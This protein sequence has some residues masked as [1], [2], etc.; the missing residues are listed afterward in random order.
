MKYYAYILQSLKDQKFYIG[1]TSKNPE[2]RLKEHN[3]KCVFSTKH[4]VPLKLVYTEEFS[5]RQEAI[6]RERKL[7]VTKRNKWP[8]AC[9]DIANNQEDVKVS[10]I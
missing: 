7:K 9:P 4:R 10:K 8:I 1:H 5:A 6:S 3:Q 2:E